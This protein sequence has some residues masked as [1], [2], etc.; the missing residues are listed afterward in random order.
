MIYLV[1]ALQ[2]LIILMILFYLLNLKKTF[3]Y[4]NIKNNFKKLNKIDDF[5]P[6]IINI[7]KNLEFIIKKM[8]LERIEE[9]KQIEGWIKLSEEEIKKGNQVNAIE[10]IEIALNH[11]PFSKNLIE[12]FSSLLVP[13]AEDDDGI[14]RRDAITRMNIKLSNFKNSCSIENYRF[15]QELQNNLNKLNTKLINESF[16]KQKQDIITKL[17]QLEKRTS[18]LLKKGKLTDEEMNELAKLD[19]VIDKSVIKANNEL[20][21]RYDKISKNVIEYFKNTDKMSDKNENKKYNT[22]AINS[23]KKAYNKFND[24]KK[25]YKKG[26]KLTE[27]VDLLGGWDNRYLLQSTLTYTSSVYAEIFQKLKPEARL[28]MTELMVKVKMKENY[29]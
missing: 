7:S 8:D 17:D 12:K 20:Q 24:N 11:Y 23:V 22:R 26:N 3:G 14:I 21:K 4:L 27:L 25:E 16:N 29:E 2:T 10:I 9:N 1:I 19:D 5:E 28:K 18:S 13:L 6:Q 15:S